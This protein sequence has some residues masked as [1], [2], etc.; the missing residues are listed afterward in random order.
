MVLRRCKSETKISPGNQHNRSLKDKVRCFFSH[1][2]LSMVKLL[3]QLAGP[4][5]TNENNFMVQFRGCIVI[6]N[7]E[8]IK[9]V[10]LR[11]CI[12]YPS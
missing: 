4:D 2:H 10:T 12:V 5:H 1:I 8:V 9:L 7:E 11:K 3:V 6:I